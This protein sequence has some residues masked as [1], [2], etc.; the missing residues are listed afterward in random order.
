MQSNNIA[1]MLLHDSTCQSL[2]VLEF[3]LPYI[4]CVVLSQE[5]TV[6]YLKEHYLQVHCKVNIIIHSPFFLVDQIETKDK[7]RINITWQL[8]EQLCQLVLQTT[9][10]TV[11]LM[12]TYMYR[13]GRIGFLKSNDEVPSSNLRNHYNPLGLEAPR[14]EIVLLAAG[15]IWNYRGV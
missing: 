3:M 5:L 7:S 2:Y 12:M 11:S 8:K 9:V 4:K 15:D 6:H 14:Q 13:C 1:N 10:D